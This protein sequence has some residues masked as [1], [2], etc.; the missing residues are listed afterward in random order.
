[1][2]SLP[3]LPMLAGSVPT[4]PHASAENAAKCGRFPKVEGNTPPCM[5]LPLKSR[6]CGIG[7]GQGQ[8]WLFRVVGEVNIQFYIYYN[9]HKIQKKNKLTCS[10]PPISANLPNKPFVPSSR[11][12]PCNPLKKFPL[13]S[14]LSSFFRRDT[15]FRGIDPV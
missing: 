12:F 6:Y 1:M 13:K 2:F 7:L 9:K 3:R 15:A 5:G 4:N 10:G 11:S 8:L 14:T